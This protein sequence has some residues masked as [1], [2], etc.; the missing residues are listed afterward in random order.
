M[1]GHHATTT[2]PTLKERAREEL[3]NY[4]IVAGYLY[5]CLAA[6][7]LYKTALL[8]QE[9]VSFVAHG[10]AVAKALI[11]GKFLLIGEAVG[12]GTRSR[13]GARTLVHAIVR[14]ALLMFVLLVVLSVLEELLVGWA[15]GHSFG[16]TLAEFREHTWLQMLAG[17]VLMLLVLLP[18]VAASEINESLGPGALRTLLFSAPDT[19]S[20]APASHEERR[21]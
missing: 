5:V 6:L 16:Q 11:L 17:G 2:K 3:R 13:R 12:V 15:H 19:S 8:R 1:P 14:K 7:V 18:L 10:L 9:G 20:T 4:A 21:R